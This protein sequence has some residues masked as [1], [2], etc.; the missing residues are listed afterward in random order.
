[1][2]LRANFCTG[3]GRRTGA[4]P[5]GGPAEL[6]R[7]T[8][9]ALDMSPDSTEFVDSIE[10][11]VNGAA[12]RIAAGATVAELVAE[13][14]LGERRVAVERNR[15]IVPRAQHGE[16]RLEPGDRLELVTFVGGG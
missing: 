3:G 2:P 16:V 7:A 11:T 13:L 6:F 12:R 15:E 1:V 4:E 5:I 9:S 10:I 14:G 8:N